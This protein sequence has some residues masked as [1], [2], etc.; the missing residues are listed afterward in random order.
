VLLRRLPR[1]L[2]EPDLRGMG[3]AMARG[4]AERGLV[5]LLRDVMVSPA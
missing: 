3:L 2:G 5:R 1:V 4:L